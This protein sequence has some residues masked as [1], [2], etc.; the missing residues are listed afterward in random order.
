MNPLA[1]PLAMDRARQVLESEGQDDLHTAHPAQADHSG[2]CITD[3]NL[4]E[5]D[6][7]SVSNMEIEPKS[8]KPYAAERENE[9]IE[10]LEMDKQMLVEVIHLLESQAYVEARDVYAAK[11]QELQNEVTSLKAKLERV[12]AFLYDNEFAQK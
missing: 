10:G 12:E 9:T 1:Q 3:I 5:A 6:Y 2:S 7:V 8:L 4:L 11:E